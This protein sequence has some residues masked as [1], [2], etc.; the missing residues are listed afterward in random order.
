MF[1]N[2][3]VKNDELFNSFVDWSGQKS[4]FIFMHVHIRV[5][6]IN[7]LHAQIEGKQCQK[8]IPLDAE[9]LMKLVLSKRDI[10]EKLE[11]AIMKS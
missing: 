3:R 5:R 11:G 6:P 7:R 4:I 10:A 1:G 2:Y 9:E 8:K